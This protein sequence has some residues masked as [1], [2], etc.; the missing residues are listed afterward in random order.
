M[1]TMNTLL[2]IGALSLSAGVASAQWVVDATVNT[3][4][5]VGIGDQTSQVMRASQDGGVWVAC[6]DS[7]LG[8]GLKHASQRLSPTGFRT[9]SPATVISPSRTN[10]AA[11]TFDMRADPAGGAVVAFDNA[12]IFVQRV[13]ANGAAV[14]PVG[15][16]QITNNTASLGPRV[17]ALVGGSYVV[18]W[19]A[20]GAINMQR[21]N[22]N[23]SLGTSFSI[24]NAGNYLAISD[25]LP[26]ENPGEFIAL[27][28]IGDAATAS[29]SRRG[30][31]MQKWNDANVPSWNAVAPAIIYTPQAS[32]LKSI[33]SG[34]FPTMIADGSGG[35]IVSW[36]DTGV[37][38]NVWLQAV[39][40]VGQ[41]R[42]ALEGLA[43][44]S[45]PASSELRLGSAVSYDRTS[46]SF[47]VA[48]VRSDT[49]QTN[50]G[51]SAQRVV[52]SSLQWG[53]GA[54]QSISPLTSQ[55]VSFVTVNDAPG[56][57]VVVSWL[58]S[59][60]GLSQRARAVR[61]NALAETVWIPSP[62]GVA[63]ASTPKGRWSVTNTVGSSMLIASWV[64]GAFGASDIK[65]QN[66]LPSGALG[67]GCDSIDF[68]ENA[69]F[70]EDQDVIDYLN[71]LAGGSCDTCGDIDFNNNGVYPEDQDVIDFFAVLAG[72]GC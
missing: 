53:G 33:Q 48:Y 30:L 7:S 45:T 16:A 24:T 58:Q 54:G 41:L 35:A 68:N 14:W 6:V 72:G 69:V 59:D 50:F 26:G 61:L 37:T 63:I 5:A 55:Q 66:I 31:Q 22:A 71:V 9:L 23:G 21:V 52:G 57:D 13:A 44:S 60:L 56:E 40:S 47:V 10:A 18:A 11:F 49:T 67:A 36:Y 2:W 43:V 29:T 25:L 38:R 51:I 8:T 1:G 64:D 32:P 34:Y 65:A 15:G 12:G 3:P 17:A 42:F 4:V 20:T 19:N 62:V 27:W 46:D 28:V 70:P 39:N